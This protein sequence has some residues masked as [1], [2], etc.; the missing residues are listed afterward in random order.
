M[1]EK[2]MRPHRDR[3]AYKEERQQ[4]IKRVKYYSYRERLEN[5]G[6][7]TLLERMRGDLFKMM[8]FLNLYWK[9]W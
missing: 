6:L 8:E 4:K 9:L 2:Y 3:R 7:T 1:F 5:I